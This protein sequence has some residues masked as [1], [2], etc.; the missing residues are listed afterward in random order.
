MDSIYTTCYL[1]PE[2][3]LFAEIQKLFI[4]V[5]QELYGTDHLY[6]ADPFNEIT[7]PSWDE[8]YLASVGKSIYESMAKAD[9]KAI[10]YQ[11]S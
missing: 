1:N 2:E 3:P 10:W 4:R 9:P 7:P 11:M 5:Q 6:S 8:N